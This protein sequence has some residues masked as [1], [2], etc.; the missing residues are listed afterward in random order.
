[1]LLL[2]TEFRGYCSQI[3]SSYLARLK[4]HSPEWGLM[5]F[6]FE[7]GSVDLPCQQIP[8]FPIKERKISAFNAYR[9]ELFIR[10][11]EDI[12]VLERQNGFEIHRLLCGGTRKR[13]ACQVRKFVSSDPPQGESSPVSDGG[14]GVKFKWR[15]PIA[16]VITSHPRFSFKEIQLQS[17]PANTPTQPQ[18]VGGYIDVWI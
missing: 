4:W 11:P 14:G 13:T 17:P 15:R 7:H 9:R 6:Y 2:L 8:V 12:H 1:M 10:M 18:A 3:S 5:V 16:T